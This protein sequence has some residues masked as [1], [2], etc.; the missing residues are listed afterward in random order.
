MGKIKLQMLDSSFSVL[1][2]ILDLHLL[3]FSTNWHIY[4]IFHQD[5]NTAKTLVITGRFDSKFELRL[6]AI[7]CV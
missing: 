6:I 1:L 5:L 3:E 4:V 2:S 7:Y